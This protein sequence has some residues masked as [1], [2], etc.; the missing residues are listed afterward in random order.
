M[1]VVP[2]PRKTDN[3]VQSF[4]RYTEGIS[5]PKIFRK[6]AAIT[7]L[8]AALERRVWIRTSKGFTYGNL[9]VIL[10]GLPGLG[11]SEAIDHIRNVLQACYVKD[12]HRLPTHLMPYDV[13]K[14]ALLDKLSE[15]TRYGP[16][17]F[18]DV[19]GAEMKVKYHSALLAIS[20]LGDLI[21]EYDSQLLSA[22]HSLWDGK[23]IIEEER[24][25][26]KDKPISI[27][28]PSLALLGGTTTAYLSRTFP[29]AAWEEGFIARTIMV[30]SS[31]LVEPDLFGEESVDLALA[32]DLVED[33]R[34]IGRL[35]GRMEFTPDAKD[36]ITKWQKAGKP[37]EPEHARLVHY[38]SRRVRQILKLSMIAAI[39]R[40]NQLLIDVEDFQTALGWLVE[41]EK[42]MPKIFLEISGRSEGHVLNELYLHARQLWDSPLSGKV[43]IRKALLIGFL[44]TRVDP[45]RVEAT[46][47]M[48]LEAE[49]LIQIPMP[50]G[51]TR[52]RPAD[53]PKLLRPG[54]RT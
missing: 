13:T 46:L 24:R 26:R 36:S 50:N 54:T 14:G 3:W 9:F 28:N 20:E 8:G 44:T 42:A 52:Y 10:I 53:K 21:R 16:D 43:P 18:S 47:K 19:V 35:V 51:E 33:L 23:G 5:S 2:K 49:L 30:Y 29:P 25:Y 7:C 12:L 31:D 17:P 22:L 45:L 1:A 48:A 4:L 38:N 34:Q 15:M 39:N 32:Q 27:D 11:K 37:P 40:G 41:A 6:W